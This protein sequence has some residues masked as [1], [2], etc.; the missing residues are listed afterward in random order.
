MYTQYICLRACTSLS[1]KNIHF[2]FIFFLIQNIYF[3][4][5]KEPINFEFVKIFLQRKV[6]RTKDSQNDIGYCC[7]PHLPSRI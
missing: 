1:W 7:G 4:A 3:K 6:C 5:I 2:I